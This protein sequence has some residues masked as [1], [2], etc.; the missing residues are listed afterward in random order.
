M[1]G[2]VLSVQVKGRV[3]VKGRNFQVKGRVLSVQVTGEVAYLSLLSQKLEMIK[4][5]EEHMLKTK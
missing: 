1:K 2:S 5:N 3:H 4:L